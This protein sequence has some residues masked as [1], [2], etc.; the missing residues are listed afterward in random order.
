MARATVVVEFVDTE[1]GVGMRV[2][3]PE[4]NGK[5]VAAK[6]LTG[7]ESLALA[8]LEDILDDL[9]A[10]DMLSVTTHIAH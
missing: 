7:A 3:S 1:G 6:D 5:T 2:M 4:L 9:G 8:L 10:G